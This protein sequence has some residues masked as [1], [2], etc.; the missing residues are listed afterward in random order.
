MS[1][2]KRSSL[3]DLL[4][5]EWFKTQPTSIKLVLSNCSTVCYSTYPKLYFHCEFESNPIIDKHWHQLWHKL[6]IP[7]F[8]WLEI[9]LS[10]YISLFINFLKKPQKSI[11]VPQF[12]NRL[13]NRTKHV[14]K[15]GRVQEN[16]DWWLAWWLIWHKKWRS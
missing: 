3:K 8:W 16:S 13:F 5:L 4:L 1:L 2:L 9:T 11:K 15:R 10:P 6:C 12:C 7:S 14:H